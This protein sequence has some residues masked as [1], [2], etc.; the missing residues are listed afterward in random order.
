MRIFQINETCE[1]SERC[2]EVTEVLMISEPCLDSRGQ[3]M[4]HGDT[5]NRC[6]TCNAYKRKVSNNDTRNQIQ[7]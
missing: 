6:K 7:R 5:A 2:A 1:N 3:T 4:I